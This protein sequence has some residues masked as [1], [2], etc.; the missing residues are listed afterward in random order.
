MSFTTNTTDIVTENPK[1]YRLYTKVLP[2]VR[3]FSVNPK[4][5]ERKKKATAILFT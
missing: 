5:S 3:K 4:K 1:T 2:K